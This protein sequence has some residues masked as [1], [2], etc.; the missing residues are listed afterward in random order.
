MTVS[1]FALKVHRAIKKIPEGRISTYGEI[2]RFLNSRGYRAVGKAAQTNLNS[3]EVP[4]HRVVMA[5]GS[6]G[7]YSAGGGVKRKKELLKKEGIKIRKE[8]IVD[9]VEVFFS[10][11]NV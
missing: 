8:K 5:D 6:I 10:F 7:G 4:C 2:A 3:P 1:N 11:K 9:F